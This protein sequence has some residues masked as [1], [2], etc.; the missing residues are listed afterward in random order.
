[1]SKVTKPI[2]DGYATVSAYL[3]VE[4]SKHAMD[5]YEKAFGAK[6]GH[7]MPGPGGQGT[8][9]AE[10][11]IGDSSFMLSDAN[12]TWGTRSAKQLGGSPVSLHV[13][14]EDADELVERAVDAG[15][16]VKFPLNDTFWGDRYA[17][18]VDPFGIEWGIA[19]HKEDL[20]EDEL[21]KRGEEWFARSS[22]GG[23]SSD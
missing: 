15:C 19:T 12:P 9:H 3:I 10:M 23:G 11:R 21:R 8:M 5:F 18:L 20:S 17:K 1:M 13:Y 2:P 14:V 22:Q 7:H 16:E 6:R 4:D